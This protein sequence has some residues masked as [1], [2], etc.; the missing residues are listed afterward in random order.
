V[1]NESVSLLSIRITYS[2]IYDIPRFHDTFTWS[3]TQIITLFLSQVVIGGS[4]SSLFAFILDT[5]SALMSS[6][7]CAGSVGS[8]ISWALLLATD[9]CVC[10]CMCVCV[11]EEETSISPRITTQC[12]FFPSHLHLSASFFVCWL[13]TPSDSSSEVCSFVL[14]CPFCCKID[15]S[16]SSA[17]SVNISVPPHSRQERF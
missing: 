12:R 14:F 11:G 5:Y 15:L 9:V 3:V 16:L 6:G 10:V 2:F 8:L 1:L 17:I 13:T 7:I 4:T